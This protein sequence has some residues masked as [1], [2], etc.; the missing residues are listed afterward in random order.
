MTDFHGFTPGRKVPV[1]TQKQRRRPPQEPDFS[2][3]VAWL[4]GALTLAAALGMA[5]G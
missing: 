1:R 4:M 3:A 2:S 5:L